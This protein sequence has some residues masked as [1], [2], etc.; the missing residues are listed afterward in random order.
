MANMLCLSATPLHIK[1]INIF[2]ENLGFSFHLAS[3]L[4]LSAI[5]LHIK[6][7]NV[8][9]E[10]LLLVLVGWRQPFSGKR[11]VHPISLVKG[12]FRIVGCGFNF[13]GKR[14]VPFSH[15][16]A[17]YIKYE[18][19]FWST[20]YLHVW[21]SADPVLQFRLDLAVPVIRILGSISNLS[22]AALSQTR[23][24]LICTLK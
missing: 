11:L 17:H 14:A 18:I 9:L 3:T 13:H 4:C 23:R 5:L 21:G 6:T 2:M 7:R 22:I 19:C 16:S 8:F 24:A 10:Y 1:T 12:V 15:S 20:F